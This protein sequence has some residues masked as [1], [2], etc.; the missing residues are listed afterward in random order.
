[1]EKQKHDLYLQLAHNTLALNP[2]LFC[3]K[4]NKETLFNKMNC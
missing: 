1:M 2:Q 3:Q 4:I